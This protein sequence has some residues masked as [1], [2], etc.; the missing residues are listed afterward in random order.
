MKTKD[1]LYAYVEGSK[2]AY[3]V[4]CKGSLVCPYS[5]KT[6]EELLKE[7]SGLQFLEWNEFEKKVEI[8]TV[9]QPREITEE[10][11]FEA[12]NCLPP[13]NWTKT[14]GFECFHMS[15]FTTSYYTGTYVHYKDKFFYWTDSVYHT[16]DQIKE[17]LFNKFPE[18]RS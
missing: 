9:T 16:V 5:G 7:K 15:E 18:L 1:Y 17:K 11:Y 6:V 2:T 13:L 4:V 12:L 3:T 10:D 8:A 14:G